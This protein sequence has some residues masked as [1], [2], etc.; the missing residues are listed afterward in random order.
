MVLGLIYS[1]YHMVMVAQLVVEGFIAN[2]PIG[3]AGHLVLE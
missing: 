2:N 3:S 1:I